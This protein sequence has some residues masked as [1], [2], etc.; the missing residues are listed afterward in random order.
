MNER[1]TNPIN[2]PLITRPG[3]SAEHVGTRNIVN[4]LPS[5]FQTTVNKQFLDTTLEQLMSS[6]SLTAINNYIGQR[7]K[8]YK[9]TDNYINDNRTADSY[10][11][12]PGVTNRDDQGNI[13]QA[14]SYDDMINSLEFNEVDINQQNKLLNETGYTLDLPINYD[15]F[16]NY[17]KYFW[18]VD[19]L[20]PCSIKPTVTNE[21]DIDD[22]VRSPYYTTPTLSTN[23]TLTLQ[24]GMRIRFM[25]SSI[26]RMLQDTVGLTSFT[27]DPAYTNC[28]TVKVYQNNVLQT[29]G[30][31]YTR[32]GNTITFTTAPVLGD[33][34]EIH[35][36][37][38]FSSSGDY[39]VGDI[40]IVD[41]VGD[42]GKIR[43]TQ[44]FESG[45][46]QGT[47]SKRTWKNHTI[48]SSQEAKGFDQDGTSF[49]FDPYDI[50]EWRM[51]TRDYYV[52]K[53]YSADQSAWARSNLWIHQTAAEA[54]VAFENLDYNT[55]LAD[56]FRAVR[57]IIEQK[58]AIEKYA[59]GRNHIAYVN[60]LIE[61]TIDPATQIVGQVSYSHDTH[62]ITTPWSQTGFDD[63]DKVYVAMGSATTY[64]ECIKTHGDPA[65]PTF[66]ENR[67][68]WKQITE[69]N[70]EDDELVL[71]IR[72]TNSAYVNRI[73]R[74]GGVTAGTGITLTEVYGPSSTAL[75]KFDKVTVIKGYNTTRWDDNELTDPYSGSEWYWNDVAWVYGQQKMHRSAGIK[76][77]LY[78]AQLT[79]LDDGIKYPDSNFAG[80][81][82]FN[83]G[84]N[85]ASK[86]DDALGFNPRYVDYGN[87]PGLSFDFGAGGKRYNYTLFNT[88]TENSQVIEIR[89]YYYY[90]NLNTDRYFNGWSA[91]RGGQN[92][93]RHAQYAIK[94]AAQPIVVNLGTTDYNLDNKFSFVLRN[95]LL[96]VDSENTARINQIAGTLP[97]LFMNRNTT[98]QIETY[99][100]ESKLRFFSFDG[101]SIS[102]DVV[103]TTTATNKIDLQ[104]V[105]PTYNA[106]RYYH[107]DF[108]NKEGVIYFDNNTSNTNIR[109][110]KN[111]QD[112]TAYTLNYN[113][114]TINSG[115]LEGDVYDITW[116]SD[117]ELT[118]ADGEFLPADTHIYNPQNKILSDSSFGDLVAHMRDQMENIPGFSGQYFG[119]NN[120]DTLPHVH[121][122]G[123]TIRQQAFSTELLAQ[124]SLDIDTDAYSALKFSA[125]Q[126]QGFKNRFALKVQQ[127]HNTLDISIPV[128]ELVDRALSDMNIGKNSD[129]SFANS[130]MAMYRDFES[131]DYHWTNTVTPVFDLPETVNT[132]DDAQNHIQ[133]WLRE[134][135]GAGKLV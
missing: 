77:R 68:Y 126:Y 116:Y 59:F 12:V 2:A 89:G 39:A 13:T 47:Y 48:Y 81:Y 34:I 67:Q 107:T 95:N 50:R 101:T 131:Y 109:V 129:S 83:Y 133:A 86:F 125:N 84:Y 118:D 72:A 82:I 28:T 51:T 58:N 25:P 16:I 57:P 65:D 6:G 128:H 76:V 3:E 96:T 37:C 1:T 18:L 132:Y 108:P 121:Q 97:T 112:Y 49:D 135:D 21:I 54:V 62:N 100:N 44:Q 102:T 5:I 117:S 22:L 122:F 91:V 127:L 38:A 46:V 123:G 17:H 120:Y 45:Q 119:D 29:Q 8:K 85:S 27:F 124:T 36:F 40:Y 103:R 9:S 30:T 114:L 55:Y 31:D 14:L 20:P 98:Y 61:D 71:F 92:V 35:S 115:L 60:Q 19:I 33:E 23:N 4:F 10:Q 66:F 94:D 90:K 32:I 11:F 26:D 93:R 111:N 99:F 64:W 52:E 134:D 75:N 105:N 113:L 80:D 53:R 79:L 110:T 87:T 15:M 41:G 24:N 106:I 78:D 69:E 104:I 63:G 130:N 88:D 42:E 7:Y 73:F 43:L 70:L 56:N 74:V